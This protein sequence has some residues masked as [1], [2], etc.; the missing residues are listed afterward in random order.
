MF[1]Q[2]VCLF[3]CAVCV[4]LIVVANCVNQLI[5]DT[6]VY[7]REWFRIV[8]CTLARYMYVAVGLL[9]FIF[10]ITL[11]CLAPVNFCTTDTI[12]GSDYAYRHVYCYSVSTL[13]LSLP[14]P[15]NSK[16]EMFASFRF[17]GIAISHS[18]SGNAYR[19]IAATFAMC[20][21]AMQNDL[22]WHLQ[23]VFRHISVVIK[24]NN[25]VVRE[26]IPPFWYIYTHINIFI[27]ST[28]DSVQSNQIGCPSRSPYLNGLKPLFYA[29]FFVRST[30]TELNTFVF[31]QCY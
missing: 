3:T 20:L 6:K 29:R 25:L 30:D 1:E 19:C 18:N 13:S 26:T 2:N 15:I 27:Y 5:L 7:Q 14:P 10:R 24:C 22:V 28:V 31:V 9:L 8:W 16:R 21:Y 12:Y 11:S 23:R 17:S 4:P